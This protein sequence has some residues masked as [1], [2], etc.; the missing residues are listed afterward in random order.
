MA[1]PMQWAPAVLD[2][3]KVKSQPRTVPRHGGGGERAPGIH[4]IDDI[5]FGSIYSLHCYSQ[6]NLDV[7]L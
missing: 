7:Q 5:L 6:V 2:Y 4:H 3:M 1:E